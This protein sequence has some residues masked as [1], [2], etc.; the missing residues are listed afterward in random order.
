MSRRNLILL[1]IVLGITAIIFLAFLFTRGGT[2]EDP[3]EEGGGNFFSSWNP[4]AKDPAP[5]QDN[6]P[7]QIPD[8]E[9]LPEEQLAAMKLKK[10]SSMPIAGYGAFQK[11][12]LKEIPP[13]ETG[14]DEDVEGEPVV[15]IPPQTEFAPAVRYAE[16][17]NGIIYQTFADKIKQ[18]KFSSTIIPKLYEAYFGNKGGTVVM[19][20]LKGGD[21]TIDTFVGVLPKEFIGE[22]ARDDYEIKGSF[23]PEDVSDISLSLDSMKMFYLFE[24]GNGVVGTTLEFTNNRKT[25]VFD[26]AFTEWLSS[27][28]NNNMIS[29]NTK[30]ASS[31]PGYLYKLDLSSRSVTKTLGPIDGLTTL[32]SPTGNFVLYSGDDLALVLYNTSSRESK[33]VGLRSLP[34]KCVWARS[35]EVIYCAVPKSSP[36]GSYPDIWYQGGVTFDDQIWRINTSTL[37]ATLLLNPVAEI[38]GEEIDGIR[39]SLDEA[40]NYLFFINKK[41]SFLWEFYL[42]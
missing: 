37:E 14:A 40:E 42:R 32:I 25:Q 22:D 4:F 16:K 21:E 33:P 31:V 26:S 23:L 10:I 7:V 41:D 15:T 30:P 1:I 17:E 28:P 11:E 13:A 12:R 9:N 35:E 29:L 2:P 24:V 8:Y 34:E 20:Y 18:T 3:S 6:Q 36:I 39:L 38:N 27:W 5:P 19:R